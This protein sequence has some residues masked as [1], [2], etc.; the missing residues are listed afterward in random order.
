M[1]TTLSRPAPDEYLAYYERYI[2]LVP[3]GNLV[4]LLVEQQLDTIGMLRRVDDERGLFAYA[5]GKWTIK[6]VIGHI[7]DAERIFAYRA[8]RFARGDSQALAGFDENAYAP[9][10]RFNERRIGGLIDEFQSIRA[11]TVHVFRYLN[12]DELT[13]RGPANG[14]PISVRA[15]GYVIAGHERHHAK[16]LRE[17]YAL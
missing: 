12:E 8:L 7:C 16:L 3:E 10:G 2:S 17:R 11:S 13:R 6:E 14:N 9:A 1:P 15:L 4:D 5:P